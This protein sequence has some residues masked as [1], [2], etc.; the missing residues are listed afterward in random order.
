MAR[1]Q[2][3]HAVV[4][5]ASMAGLLTA[6]VLSESFR[7]VTVIERDA[8]PA[9]AGQRRGVPQG[10][11]LHAL[12]C[13]GGQILDDLFPGLTK[14]V[15][16]AG[17]PVGDLLGNIRWFLSGHRLAQADIGQ[18]VLFA[19]RPMLEAHVRSMV[20]GLSGVTFLEGRDIIGPVAAGNK[21][22]VTG[23]RVRSDGGAEDVIDADLIV[24][25]TGRASRAPVWLEE[26]GYARPV[27]EKVTVDVAY[28]TRSYRL[29]PD[30]LGT[31]HLIMNFWT[32]EH[33]RAAGLEKTGDRFLLTAAGLLGDHP[34]TD[35]K[36][37]DEFVASLRFPDIPE[38][39]RAGEPLDDP[40]AFRY[41]ANVRQRYE[42][43]RD[44]PEGFLVLGDAVCAFNPIY[45]QG[46][47]SASLQAIALRGLLADGQPLT[48][49]RHFQAMAK[50]V[51]DPWTISTGNDLGFPGVTGKR[52]PLVRIVNA[53]LPRLHEL[54]ERDPDA[55]AAFLRVVGLLE[56]PQTMLR[57]RLALRVLTRR[58]QS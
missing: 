27:A 18:P 45:G 21:R 51:D 39:I 11:H 13:R 3:E 7:E 58:W 36:G 22:R 33:P 15:A 57:P 20:K 28:A 46:M 24:D 4:L 6:R 29:P 52:T 48:W 56:R 5:G 30:I 31:D 47:T 8:L 17:A 2:G 50:A 12:L 23:V 14:Q 42:R 35:P 1:A 19:T 54:G 9:E 32:P 55:A 25:T 41:P 26:L 43:M 49:R 53:Y 37:F 40:V 10:R 44:F 16:E 38:A 34:P